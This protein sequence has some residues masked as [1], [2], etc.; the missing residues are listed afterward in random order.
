[1]AR[2]ERGVGNGP[3]RPDQNAQP[4]AGARENIAEIQR[5]REQAIGDRDTVGGDP[6]AMLAASYIA[7]VG[8]KQEI[9]TAVGWLAARAKLALVG[10]RNGVTTSMRS[11]LNVWLV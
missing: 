3:I 9:I 8:R 5:D 1:M 7:V 11:S 10:E 2:R 4:P 6:R